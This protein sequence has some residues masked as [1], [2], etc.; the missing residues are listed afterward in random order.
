MHIIQA[1]RRVANIFENTKLKKSSFFHKDPV[2]QYR[3]FNF[4][5]IGC[6][7]IDPETAIVTYG[8]YGPNDY[9]NNPSNDEW[10]NPEVMDLHA[11]R[12]TKSW[13]YTRLAMVRG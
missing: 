13:L 6:D 1:C 5:D 8:F 9:G 10:H 11:V 7:F 4:F 12:L 3:E 2:K